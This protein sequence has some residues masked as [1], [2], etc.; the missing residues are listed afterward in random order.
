MRN[1]DFVAFKN[2]KL[3]EKEVKRDENIN[4][5]LPEG[6]N[7]NLNVR[8]IEYPVLNSKSPD[9]ILTLKLYH[10]RYGLSTEDVV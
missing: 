5:V 4:C 2:F 8:T 10:N 3:T 9:N 6:V 7:L 1:N